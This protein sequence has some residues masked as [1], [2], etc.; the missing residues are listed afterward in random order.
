M[1][2]LKVTGTVETLFNT[3]QISDKFRKREL[4]LNTGPVDYP[5]QVVFQFTN[6]LCEQLDEL[7]EGQNIT[8]YFNLRGRQWTNPKTGESRYFNTLNAWKYELEEKTMS[9]LTKEHGKTSNGIINN[10]Q[11]EMINDLSDDDDLPF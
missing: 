4:V 1:G 8:I 5:Q 10:F 11:E 3:Q 9:K 6:D 2:E 7:G